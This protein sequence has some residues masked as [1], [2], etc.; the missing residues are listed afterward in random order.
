MYAE[1]EML[2]KGVGV[3]KVFCW[4]G[5]TGLTVMLTR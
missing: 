1:K 3:L 5:N 2:T 4:E